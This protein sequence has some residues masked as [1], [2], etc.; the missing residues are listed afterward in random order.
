MHIL[1]IED[2]KDAA[3]YLIKGLKESGHVTDHASDGEEGLNMA[4]DSNFDVLIVDR[5]LPK[6]EGLTLIQ[7]LRK[8]GNDTPILVLSALGEVDERVKGLK[9]GADDYLSKPFSFSELL[10]RIEALSRRTQPESS[11]TLLEVGDLSIDLL[12]REVH[13]EGQKIELQ[14][15]EYR[16]L[17]FLMRRPN[18]VVTRTMLL[19]GV[20]EYHFDPQ[21]NVIDVHIS[22]L[23]SKIDKPFKG[24]Q[25]LHTERG[26]GYALRYD[27]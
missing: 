26:A 21:T 25:M 15:R 24:K 27:E 16:L 9:F 10:A 3:A 7:E 13:R 18:Q 12:S 17:E 8:E 19:E 1:L 2:D 20:W 22:R 4:L 11:S 5:M 14:P 6:I 23:R